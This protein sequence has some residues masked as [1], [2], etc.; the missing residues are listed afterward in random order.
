M[1]LSMTTTFGFGNNWLKFAANLSDE[2]IVEAQKSLQKLLG[3]ADLSGLTFLDIG[4]GSGLSSLVARRLGTRVRSFDFDPDSV[5]CT[6]GLREKYFPGDEDWTV[7][8][9]SI[10]DAVYTQRL[11]TFDIVYSWGV[12]HHTGAM[13]TALQRAASMVAPGGVLAVALYRKTPLCGV[14]RIEKRFYAGAPGMVQ[15]VM[16]GAYK[17][18]YLTGILATGR[19]PS[20]YVRGYKSARGMNW[21]RDVHDWLGG[22]PYESASPAEVKA[23]LAQ[24]GFGIVRSFERPAGIGLFGTGCDEFVCQR[25]SLAR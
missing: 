12:L 8:R 21:H 7:E 24:L 20:A 19:N 16:R 18:A 6:K 15:A 14:W 4:C 17:A 13:W 2:Q 11:G 3:R 23:H 9:G 1:A 5:A 10:L 25:Q 22:Y